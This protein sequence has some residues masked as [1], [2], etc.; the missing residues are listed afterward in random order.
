MAYALRGLTG[1]RQALCRVQRV[2]ASVQLVEAQHRQTGDVRLVMRGVSTC[3]SGH[4]CPQCAGRIAAVRGEELATA[5]EYWGRGRTAL[6]TLTVRHSRRMALEPLRR[7]LAIA[8]SDLYGG[9]AGRALKLT[10]GIKHHVRGNEQTV[11]PNGWHPH[12]HAATFFDVLLTDDSIARLV[13]ELSERWRHCI[14]RAWRRMQRSFADA[15]GEDTPQL[16]AKLA[17]LWGKRNTHGSLHEAAANW[18]TKWKTLGTL[19][20]VLPDDRHG[21]DVTRLDRTRTY[22]TK[23]GLEVAGIANKSSDGAHMTHWEVYRRAA[24]GDRKCRQLVKEHYVAMRGSALL[25]WSRG[26]R[27]VCGL[28]PERP[29]AEVA[30]EAPE[31]TEDLRLLREITAQEWDPKAGVGQLWAAYLYDCHAAGELEQDAGTRGLQATCWAPQHTGPPD[32]R[33]HWLENFGRQRLAPG[34]ALP[35]VASDSYSRL[36]RAERLLLLEELQHRI[37]IESGVCG[38]DACRTVRRWKLRS[39]DCPF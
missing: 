5:L 11:G 22:L 31:P 37:A 10:H 13:P 2:S 38:Q 29:D 17:R 34:I 9:R 18:Q 3:G 12:S 7:L 14:A 39:D 6:V 20:E 32:V 27:A 23:L 15:M 16:R 30:T 33:P 28:Q 35:D 19:D 8:Q 26:F 4:S 24:R 1:R 25:V 36:P 21:V